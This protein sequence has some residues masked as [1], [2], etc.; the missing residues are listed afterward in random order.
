[1]RTNI[2][3]DD[4]L[5]DEAMTLTGIKTKREVVHEA[6]RVLIEKRK[7]LEAVEK[8]EALR[9]KITF[10]DDVLEDLEAHRIPENELSEQPIRVLG[11]KKAEYR[12]EVAKESSH[13]NE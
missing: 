12:V 2:V 10:W 9:G 3:I 8:L 7:R 13:E 11:E 6:L 5:I 1:M 4:E